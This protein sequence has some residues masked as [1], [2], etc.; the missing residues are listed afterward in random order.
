[1]AVTTTKQGEGF[2]GHRVM[3]G[4]LHR[5]SSNNVWFWRLGNL[6]TARLIVSYGATLILVWNDL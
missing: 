1:M 3:R 6:S 2:I 5:L 4:S